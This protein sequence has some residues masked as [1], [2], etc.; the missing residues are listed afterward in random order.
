MRGGASF[1]ITF[2]PLPSKKPSEVHWV[3][4]GQLCFHEARVFDQANAPCISPS[5]LLHCAE[6]CLTGC[7]WNRLRSLYGW[8]LQQVVTAGPVE[9][10]PA[11]TGVGIKRWLGCAVF[12]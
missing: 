3:S 9:P 6:Y 4:A 11:S 10:D 5:R 8:L 2:M 1:Y 7:R 12:T